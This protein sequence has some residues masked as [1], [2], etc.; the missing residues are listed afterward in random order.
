MGYSPNWSDALKCYVY[1]LAIKYAAEDALE[2]GLGRKIA[3]AISWGRWPEDDIAELLRQQPGKANVV[4]DIRER[5]LAEQQRIR[6]M[7]A[8]R[9]REYRAR[10]AAARVE[11]DGRTCPVCG[12]S[13]KGRRADA[14]VCST[15]CRVRGH[16]HFGNLK[17]LALDPRLERFKGGVSLQQRGDLAIAS[18]A[19]PADAADML[20]KVSQS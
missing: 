7:E 15:K 5:V 1:P 17:S 14:V 6:G 18:A 13:M 3:K 4:A 16:R 9:S 11:A 12:G 2:A 19:F 8:A 10:R 20:K